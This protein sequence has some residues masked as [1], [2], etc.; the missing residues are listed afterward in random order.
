M[1]K[2]K[3][4]V[5]LRLL[6]TKGKG[7]LLHLNDE[8]ENSTITTTVKDVLK[9]KHPDAVAATPNNIIAA[10]LQ[11][12]ILSSLNPSMQHRYGPLL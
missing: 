1:F 5:A 12:A 10:T 8:I 7:G 2:G 3:T 9:T 6:S 4:Q 11:I